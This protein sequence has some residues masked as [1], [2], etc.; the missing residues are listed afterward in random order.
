MFEILITKTFK[1]QLNNLQPSDQDF[2]VDKIRSLSKND[3]NL[4]I[5]KINPKHLDCYRLRAGKYR[6]IYFY[7]GKHKITLLK[8]DKRDNVYFGS[9]N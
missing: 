9:W 4:D 2:V 6:I 5:R 1:K 7:S 8:I 3:Q